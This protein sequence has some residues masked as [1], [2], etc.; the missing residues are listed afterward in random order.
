MTAADGARQAATPASLQA[1]AFRR[2]EAV[3]P[4]T[5]AGWR[6]VREQWKALAA[7]ESDPLRA[8]EARVRAI[9][10]AREAWRAEGGDA[11]DEA[12]FRAEADSYLGREDARQKARVEGLLADAASAH[13][14]P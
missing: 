5:A 10:A 13:R 9:I 12:A 6:S 7:A 14:T 11:G 4:R 3:R 1:D 8:D 2:L